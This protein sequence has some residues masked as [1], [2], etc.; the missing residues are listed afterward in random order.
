M[1]TLVTKVTKRN[2]VPLVHNHDQVN[3]ITVFNIFSRQ[4]WYLNFFR[5]RMDQIFGTSM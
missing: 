5:H 2:S 4:T 1:Q 3:E